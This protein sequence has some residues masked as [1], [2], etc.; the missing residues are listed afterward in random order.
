MFHE[1]KMDIVPV[2][3]LLV[4]SPESPNHESKVP[5]RAIS[6]GILTDLESTCSKWKPNPGFP[7]ARTATAGFS[8]WNPLR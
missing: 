7:L 2:M 6:H 1:L 3:N 5:L 8:Q 4:N